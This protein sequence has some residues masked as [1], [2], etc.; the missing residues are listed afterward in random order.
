MAFGSSLYSPPADCKCG[1]RYHYG[2]QCGRPPFGCSCRE[3]EAAEELGTNPTL[4]SEYYQ[5][6]IRGQ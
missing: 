1:H 2:R 5:N 3:Y 4:L 6:S